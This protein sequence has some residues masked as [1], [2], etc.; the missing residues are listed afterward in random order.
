MEE[1]FPEPQRKMASPDPQ[2]AVDNRKE[3]L[4]QVKKIDSE[5]TKM[6]NQAPI[7]NPP[8]ADQSKRGV[9][10]FGKRK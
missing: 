10:G 6:T 2:V 7:H 4:E 9:F 3:I 5:I 8:A 1:P